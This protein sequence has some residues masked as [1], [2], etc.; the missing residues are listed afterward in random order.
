MSLPPSMDAEAPRD[1]C[2]LRR[3][4]SGI[5][6]RCGGGA[7]PCSGS[8]RSLHR[9]DLSPLTHKG[10]VPF[11]AAWDKKRAPP[12][13]SPKKVIANDEGGGNVIRRLGIRLGRRKR[14]LPGCRLIRTE[15]G[16]DGRIASTKPIWRG[17]RFSAM[18]Q[19]TCQPCAPRRDWSALLPEK[20]EQ[21]RPGTLIFAEISASRPV[22][23]V[24]A[25]EGRHAS[26]KP[27]PALGKA[28]P[29]KP[30]QHPGLW[31]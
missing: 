13:W 5:F 10:E 3:H 6:C 21:D 23:C 28:G 9:S 2:G 20:S 7:H 31:R 16:G 17:R 18:R 8:R 26:K 29:E 24:A 25:S 15:G 30:G 14:R 11:R 4:D 22:L 12:K 19:Q 1:R 27:G